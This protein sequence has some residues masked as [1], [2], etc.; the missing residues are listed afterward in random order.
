MSAVLLVV[1]TG[2]SVAGITSFTATPNVLG[3]DDVVP[4]GDRCWLS[5]AVLKEVIDG[6]S[7]SHIRERGH[8]LRGIWRTIIEC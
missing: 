5:G 6:R 3:P 4:R 8:R 2:L 1:L 7:Q